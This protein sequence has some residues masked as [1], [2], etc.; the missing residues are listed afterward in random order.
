M[1]KIEGYD[2]TDWHEYEIDWKENYVDFYIDGHNVAHVTKGVPQEKMTID[3][4]LDNAAW[5]GFRNGDI[6]FPI[7]QRVK[8]ANLLFIDYVEI[9][10]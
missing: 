1:I 2:I 6:Y 7:Y 4:W 9:T 3:I 10:E 5:Y 8:T